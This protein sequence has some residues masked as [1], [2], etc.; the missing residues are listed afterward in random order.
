VVVPVGPA[1]KAEEALFQLLSGARACLDREDV[2]LVGGHSS[3]G[4]E[5]ALGFSVTGAVQAD[6]IL[7]KGGLKTG[8]ALILTRPLGTGIIFAAAMRGRAGAGCVAAAIAEMRRSNRRASEIL[9]GHGAT[10][11]TDVTGF[12]LI[13]H[14]GEML[15]ASKVGA[16]LDMSAMP[17]Y[18]G[19]SGLARAGVASTLLPENLVML[20]LLSSAIDDP[21]KAVLFDPQTSGGLL[22]GI[23]ADRSAACL[24]QLRSAGYE[25]AVAIGRIVDAGS[26][27]GAIQVSGTLAESA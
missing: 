12:G 23:P 20:R 13:G 21:T 26:P 19:V 14:L 2:A 16:E 17:T 8:D 27:T 7:R 18:D 9:R 6:R 22:A 1:S 24:A 15:T 25:H 4:M 3:E 11:M 5:L 10:A